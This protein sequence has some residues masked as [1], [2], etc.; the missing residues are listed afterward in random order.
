MM[1]AIK[2]VTSENSAKRRDQIA[3]RDVG[4]SA[5]R[6]R[7]IFARFHGLRHGIGRCG[8]LTKTPPAERDKGFADD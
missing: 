8:G 5:M 7:T 6:R 2:V 4:S 3:S 1:T